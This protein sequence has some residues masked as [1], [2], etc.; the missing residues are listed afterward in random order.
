M[1]WLLACS[2]LL[3]PRALVG[4]CPDG[5]PPPCGARA[6]TAPTSV[7]VLYFDNLSHDSSDAYLADGMTEELISRLS[8]VERL[9]VKSRTAVQ[10]LR[11]RP[12]G[13]P[14]GL[15]RS[16]AVAH[17]V[18][19]SV[20]RSGQRLRVTVE[21]MRAATGVSV[22]GRTFDRPAA[23]LIGVEAEIAESVAVGVSGRLAPGERR[24]LE[25]RPTTNA[26]AY[27]HYLRGS[28]EIARRT[29][30]SILR[31]IREYEIAARLDP[32]FVPPL[33]RAAGGYNMLSSIYAGPEVGMPRD[34]LR[35]R[36]RALVDRALRID[37][38]SSDA[39]LARANS[40]VGDERRVLDALAHATA[41]D[42]RSAEAHHLY[43]IHLRDV[44]DDSAAAAELRSALA[45]EPDRAITL[46][47]LGELFATG[48]QFAEASRW[49]DSAAALH[50]EAAFYYVEMGLTRLQLGDTAGARAA[51]ALTGSHGGANG[52]E[53]LLAMLEARAGDSAA[54]RARL[55]RV[56]SA[57]RGSDC[58]VSHPCVELAWAL[59]AVGERERALAVLERITPRNSWIAYWS[60][61]AEWDPI[62]NDPR[63]QAVLREA[64]RP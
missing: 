22:W 63:F 47:N 64:S 30:T 9:Q 49:T 21:L 27:D 35:A 58:Y 51:A 38:T 41:M 48:R 52:Q 2:L 55:V 17:L 3:A 46:I 45:L 37:S 25:V 60:R 5:T 61:R 15:G 57:M 44:G 36:S 26:A 40:I 12:L 39:W 24:R 16:L 7:A 18:S 33:V 4:Q 56:D 50:P 20:L 1:R 19:G 53:E 23:D 42:P 54:A 32:R 10:R 14:A 59:A 8:Q 11:G 43:G 34:T 31:A 13:D 62:R 28:F 6:A 29:T